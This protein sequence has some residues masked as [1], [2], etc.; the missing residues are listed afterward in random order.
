MMT[1]AVLIFPSIHP[2]S[3][4]PHTAPHLLYFNVTKQYTHH[5]VQ[6]LLAAMPLIEVLVDK[7]NS[8]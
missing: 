5:H 7:E 2:G 3:A 4:L 6:E 1:E 8:F